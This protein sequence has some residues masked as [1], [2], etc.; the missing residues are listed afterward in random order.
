VE[1]RDPREEEILMRLRHVTLG[2][3]TVVFCLALL[4]GQLLPRG[5]DAGQGLDPVTRAKA[6]IDAFIHAL[7]LYRVY[8]KR[9]PT[10][11]EG[12]EV[13]KGTAKRLD[14]Y[15]E[16]FPELD[17]WGNPYTYVFDGPKPLVTSLGADGMEGGEGIDADIRS[18]NLAGY[19]W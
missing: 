1:R 13:L 15:L 14:G 3:A 4:S 10:T 16:E 17:P 12:L 9:Y 6:D 18:D 11:D 5:C 2:G 8:E 19:G 7:G